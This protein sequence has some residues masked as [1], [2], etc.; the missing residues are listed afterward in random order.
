MKILSKFARWSSGPLLPLLVT[1]ACSGEAEDDSWAS[2]AQA[3][4]AATPDVD[5]TLL[6]G[7]SITLD[8]HVL[9]PEVPPKLDLYLVVD[10]SG[11]Y[12]DDLPNLTAKAPDIFDGVRAGVADSRFGLGSIVDYPF[13][14]WGY[15]DT[16][17]YAYRIDQDLTADRT[18][19]L[20]AMNAMVTLFGGDGPQS[21]LEAFY[22]AATGAGRD[23][24]GNGSYADL[25]DVPPAA[26]SFRADAT[27]IVALTTD[28][29]FH[30][31]GE[32]G[33]LPGGYPGP[34]RDDTVAAL[35]AAGIKV[36]AI[37]AP[38]STAEM[39]DIASAT[40]GA[41]TTTD[42]SSSQ[43][44]DA[45]LSAL[46]SLKFTITGVPVGCGPLSVSLEPASFSGV[47][48]GTT[49]I[50]S[51]T[52]TAPSTTSGGDIHCQVIFYADSTEIGRQNIH[53]RIGVAPVDIKPGSCPNPFQMRSN[54]VLPVAILGT[55]SFD[56][57]D[58]NPATV[59]LEGVAPLRYVLADVATPFEPYYGKQSSMDCTTAGPDGYMDLSLK[60]SHPA[61]AAALGAVSDR[62][63]RPLKLTGTLWDGSPF[64]GQ[65]VVL[66][67]AN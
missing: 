63:A 40:G 56:V 48:G 43:I 36:I 29:P 31:P 54:G 62:E 1:A 58:V 49:V 45:I 21:Q 23:L 41:V 60:F 35:T 9:V 4:G 5:V 59:R 13:Y 55:A 18:T 27:K 6:P 46:Q 42:A 3:E 57:N 11:S 28:A 53:V 61:V 38:G 44:A 10:L 20:T 33:D 12:S 19:W 51:E 39:D 14:P 52:I 17:D 16:G 47:G 50:F 2:G 65:D 15:A 66:I 22:Q 34:S 67:I 25:G 24:N 26:V 37:K 32:P 64:A 30:Q 7:Q 8:K